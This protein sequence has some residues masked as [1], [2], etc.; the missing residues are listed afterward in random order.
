V[1]S[2]ENK[3]RDARL[4]WFIHIRRRKMDAPERKCEKIDHL[5][6]R[7]SRDRPKKSWKEVIRYDLKTLGLVEDMA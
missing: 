4:R 2:I 6:Y 3:I 1:A 7:R 5:D